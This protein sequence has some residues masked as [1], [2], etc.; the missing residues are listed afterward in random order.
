MKAELFFQT[1]PWAEAKR[2]ADAGEFGRIASIGISEICADADL[3]TAKQR[4][5]DRLQELLGKPVSSDTVSCPQALSVLLRYDGPAVVRIFLD[6][7]EGG[8]V[9]TFEI[10][11]TDS[12]VVYKPDL[13]ALSI[14]NTDGATTRV[15]QHEYSD[16]LSRGGE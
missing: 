16:S 7:S 14:I 11:G 2:L 8:P 1:D 10:V 12:L 9:S 13:G 4:W 15:L 5:L 6:R 3:E